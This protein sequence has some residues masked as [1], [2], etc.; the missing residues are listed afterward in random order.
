MFEKWDVT[1]LPTARL[2]GVFESGS[3]EWHA[4]RSQGVGGSQVGAILG[5]N[6][7]ESAFSMWARQLGLI[8]DRESSLAMRAGN[9][10]E[11]PVKQFWL[12]ENPGWVLY[13]TGTWQSK[14]L[15][16]CHANPDGILVDE[17]G[18]LTLLEIK[19]SRYPLGEVPAHYRAQVLWYL[20]ILGLKKAKLVAWVSGSEFEEFDIVYDEFDVQV[21]VDAVKRWWACVENGEQPE[22]DGS[23]ATYEIVRQLHPDIDAD[24]VVDLGE[25]GVALVNAQT[26]ADAAQSLLTEL[27]SRT[28]DF[29]GKA[30]T[31]TV[32]DRV[33]AVR[34]A[35]NGGS[36]FLTIKK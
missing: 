1:D 32:G 25:L 34:S 6:P 12:A 9:F 11:N 21:M 23:T 13:E 31:A 18:D 14:E 4:L 8:A 2:L 30:K 7:W 33:V 35:R 28:L 36:P 15:E 16:W 19:T 20:W 3:P 29:M 26:D 10:F 27:K 5:L 24:G 17:N 22:W